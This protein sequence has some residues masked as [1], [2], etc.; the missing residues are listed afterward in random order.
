MAGNKLTIPALTSEGEIVLL[1]LVEGFTFFPEK[2]V[3][4]S[5]A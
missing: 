2:G 1:S 5:Q 4:D 3:Q